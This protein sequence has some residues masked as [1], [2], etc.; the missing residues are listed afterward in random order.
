MISDGNFD[1]IID[2]KKQDESLLFVNLA[3]FLHFGIKQEKD[4]VE[5]DKY[6]LKKV[7]Y[8]SKVVDKRFR[9]N[10]SCLCKV[11]GCFN[12]LFQLHKHILN[13]HVFVA[14]IIFPFF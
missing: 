2:G 1:R 5:C 7:S 12:Q 8:Y 4:V 11:P 14:V 6:N 13:R 10:L 9:H 3:E